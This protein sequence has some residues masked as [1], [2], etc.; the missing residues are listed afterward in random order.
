MALAFSG[1]TD[2]TFLAAVAGEELGAR[3]LAVTA[4][5]PVFPA[6]EQREAVELAARLGIR[7]ETVVTHEMELPA[8]AANPADRCYYCKRALF[9][10]VRAAAQRGG[11]DV[12][13]DGTNAD[14][15]ADR[16]P[17]RCAAAEAGAR[18][19]LLD[20]G[21]GKA[22]IRAL[23]REKGLPTANKPAQ[24]CLASRVPYGSPITIEKL[25]AVD[26][27][28][29]AVRETG[30]R[31]VRVRHHGE[32]ARIEVGPDELDRL[33]EPAVRER[34]ARAGRAAGF[35]YVSADF[36]GYRTGSLNEALRATQGDRR[37][38]G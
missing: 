27:L 7:H 30:F 23:S 8:F 1:G 24:A 29:E 11:I 6:R 35:L 36:S 21:L 4:V 18:S 2:S 16:R 9:A 34:I 3:A 32:L 25:R 10:A 17:G 15:L 33:W 26:R 22:E 20:A 28:E 19:P 12:I 13:A 5:S 31:Q 38:A 37:T 14:D